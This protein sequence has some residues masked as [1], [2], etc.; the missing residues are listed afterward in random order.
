MR[1][2]GIINF[3][4]NAKGIC[5]HRGSHVQ[6]VLPR[7]VKL[8]NGEIKMKIGDKPSGI[9]QVVALVRKEANPTAVIQEALQISNDLGADKDAQLWAEGIA[10]AAALKVLSQ[11]KQYDPT[12]PTNY[13]PNSS[14][15]VAAKI[16]KDPEGDEA[17]KLWAKYHLGLKK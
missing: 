13:H 15:Y 9:E 6:I 7:L 10:W 11:Q 12:S 8:S 17:S 5:P 14:E 3:E 1:A 4:E 2:N 16:L